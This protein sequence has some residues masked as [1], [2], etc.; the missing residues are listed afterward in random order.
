MLQ[1]AASRCIML[2]LASSAKMQAR[3][4]IL[5]TSSGIMRYYATE[6]LVCIFYAIIKMQHHAHLDDR[7]LF[8]AGEMRMMRHDAA[9]HHLAGRGEHSL[10]GGGSFRLRK[11]KLTIL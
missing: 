1:D 11:S 9:S 6:T 7:A 8:I 5:V 10:Y 2:H 3:W 4:S